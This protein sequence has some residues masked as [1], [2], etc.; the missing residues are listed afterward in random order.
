MASSS[1]KIRGFT[2]WDECKHPK[3]VIG[4]TMILRLQI[5]VMGLKK[6][7]ALCKLSNLCRKYRPM[8]WKDP[9]I[10]KE[11]YQESW[12]KRSQKRFCCSILLDNMSKGPFY[13][14]YCF[15]C[16]LK[17]LIDPPKQPKNWCPINWISLFNQRVWGKI[18]K[19]SAEGGG[20][21]DQNR[22]LASPKQPNQFQHKRCGR[23]L[24]L[25]GLPPGF[26]NMVKAI[27]LK[28]HPPN[29]HKQVV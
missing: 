2:H 27:L 23:L 6:A 12:T 24:S 4:W 8:C 22:P 28:N 14:G 20:T 17:L 29:H 3:E 26:I 15:S 1:N 25:H 16:S 13:L 9:R 18:R 7:S 19:A 5:W 11:I 10:G 21:C